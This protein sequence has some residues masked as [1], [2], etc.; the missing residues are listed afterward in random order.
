MKGA[1]PLIIFR[2]TLFVLL[3]AATAAGVDK[4]PPAYQQGTITNSSGADKFY[5]LKGPVTS[6]RIA[7]CGD[8][9]TGAAVDFRVKDEKIYISRDGGKEDKCSIKQKWLTN[10]GIAAAT[11][12]YQPGTITGWSTRLETISGSSTGLVMNSKRRTKIYELK[13]ADMVYQIANCGSFQ[14]GQFTPGQA[15]EYRVDVTEK[16]IYIRRDN[17]KEYSCIMEGVRTTDA[18]KTTAD[19]PTPH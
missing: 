12:K 16:R 15:V 19:P 10:P 6:Y 7:N 14:A 5:D 1:S 4:T 2:T 3:I 11:P 17:D 18:A 13:G 8:F 9:K